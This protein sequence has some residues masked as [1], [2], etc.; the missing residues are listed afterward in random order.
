MCYESG[1]GVTMDEAEAA[2][3]YQLA[4][5]QGDPKAQFNLG[6]LFDAVVKLKF[7]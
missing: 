3:L 4:A 1:T 7:L 6:N 5:D 2:R